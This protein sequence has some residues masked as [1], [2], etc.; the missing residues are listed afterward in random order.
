MVAASAAACVAASA[1]LG[2]QLLLPLLFHLLLLSLIDWFVILASAN[3]LHQ[4]L[5]VAV[6]AINDAICALISRCNY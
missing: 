5:L 4:I 6:R 3:V 1:P 2:L